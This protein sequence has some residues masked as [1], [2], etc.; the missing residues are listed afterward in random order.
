MGVNKNALSDN[1]GSFSIQVTEKVKS[2]K[3]TYVGFDA[4]EVSITGVSTVTVSLSPE[5]KALNDVVV[6]G[7]G[8]QKKRD[9]TGSIASVKGEAL[10]NKPT[11]SFEQ[12]LGGRAAGVQVVIPSGVLNAPPVLRIRGANSISLSSYPLIVVDGVPVFTGDGSSQV[13]QVTYYHLSI[14]MILKV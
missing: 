12:A 9:I 8:T 4:K 13:Q 2:L 7:Y 3:I 1:N 6:V 5:D 14:Q 10:A 11:Q